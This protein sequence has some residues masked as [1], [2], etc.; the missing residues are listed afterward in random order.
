MSRIRIG[1]VRALG[2]E[3]ATAG[4]RANL[5]EWAARGL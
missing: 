2:A 1:N 4:V 3:G 5:S